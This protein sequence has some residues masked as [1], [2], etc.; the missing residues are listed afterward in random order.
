MN[1]NFNSGQAD[2]FLVKL[3]KISRCVCLQQV[4]RH[5]KGLQPAEA[6]SNQTLASTRLFHLVWTFACKCLRY[7]RSCDA[8]DEIPPLS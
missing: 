4:H 5:G 7:R 1:C 3:L 6:F 8:K 2:V